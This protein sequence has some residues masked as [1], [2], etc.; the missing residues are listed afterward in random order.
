MSRKVK[1]CLALFLSFAV[2]AQYSFTPQAMVAYGMD[3]TVEAAQ[4]EDSGSDRG[5]SSE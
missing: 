1:V 4:D 3:N 2:L 5:Q